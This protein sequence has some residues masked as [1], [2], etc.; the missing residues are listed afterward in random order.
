MPK[1]G[2][3]EPSLGL[4]WLVDG[5]P[6]NGDGSAETGEN[7]VVNVSLLSVLR[8]QL[9]LVCVALLTQEIEVETV[10]ETVVEILEHKDCRPVADHGQMLVPS[11]DTEWAVERR[12][13]ELVV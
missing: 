6:L 10:V 11:K 1:E 7:L 4:Y 8:A 12:G 9:E 5:R 2:Y 3:G 13:P